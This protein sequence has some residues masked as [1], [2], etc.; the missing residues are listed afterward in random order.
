MIIADSI[1]SW[2]VLTI[3]MISFVIKIIKIE[4]KIHPVKRENA[5]SSC[6]MSVNWGK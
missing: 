2:I 5:N 1:F 6:C 4:A 3:L